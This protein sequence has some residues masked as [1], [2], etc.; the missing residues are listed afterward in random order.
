MKYIKK[1]ILE[2]NRSFVKNEKNLKLLDI[3]IMNIEQDKSKILELN[4][5]YI[6]V[7]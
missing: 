1:E 3:N 5:Q 7:L 6:T 2:Q 4:K